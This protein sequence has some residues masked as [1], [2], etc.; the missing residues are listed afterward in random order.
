[1]LFLSP[2]IVYWVQTLLHWC[3]TNT[4][5]IVDPSRVSANSLPQKMARSKINTR[6]AFLK[7]LEWYTK[8]RIKN[9]KSGQ[10]GL[11]ICN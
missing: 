8:K 2:G 7:I 3:D 1:M 10:L 5:F 6:N 4:V 11:Q 9:I